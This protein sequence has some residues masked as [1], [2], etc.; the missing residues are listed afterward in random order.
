MDD[1]C[2]MY[3]ASE[4]TVVGRRKWKLSLSDAGLEAPPMASEHRNG[5]E[6]ADLVKQL[7][8]MDD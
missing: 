8:E 3:H 1:C 4:R 5:G 7:T 2:A 6:N